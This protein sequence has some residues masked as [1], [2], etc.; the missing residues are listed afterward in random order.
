MTGAGARARLTAR[1]RG[2]RA[3]LSPSRAERPRVG[4][5]QLPRAR[6]DHE[7]TAARR[8]ASQPTLAPAPIER[9]ARRSTPPLM[10]RAARASPQHLCASSA[11]PAAAARTRPAAAAC[12][13][14]SRAARAGQLDQPVDVRPELVAGSA[15]R[16]PPRVALRR[17]PPSAPGR[18]RSRRAWPTATRRDELGQRRITRATGSPASSSQSSHEDVTPCSRAA[19]RAAHDQALASR[20][21]AAAGSAPRACVRP[22]R[23][24]RSRSCARVSGRRT[25]ARARSRSARVAA[26]ARRS[27]L[28]QARLRRS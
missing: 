4:A 25:P 21:G 5:G 19:H 14:R 9:E 23:S 1:A 3:P 24:S 6:L 12:T 7:R 8:S 15:A 10:H 11:S 13:G 22:A 16:A 17:G 28:R 18:A 20:H 2:S 27:D 26:I